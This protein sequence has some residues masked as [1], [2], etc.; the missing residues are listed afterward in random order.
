MI[1]AVIF[2]LDSCLSAADE[3]GRQLF[4]P[5][6]DAIVQ[7]SAGSH[8]ESVLQQAFHDM[9][10]IPYDVVAQKYAFTP[11]ML[12][13]GW[14]EMLQVEVRTP[15]FGYGDLG[16]LKTLPAML[17]LVTSGFRRL[18]ESKIRALGI[19]EL[20]TAVYVD[21]ID[22]PNHRGKEKLMADILQSRRLQPAEVLVVGDSPD[23]ELAVGSRL[24]IATVQTL[25]PGVP[26][27]PMATHHI[28]RLDELEP[29]LDAS[30]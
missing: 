15:M 28:R 6:F 18:Q 19:G 4:Q 21:A 9:W 14:K 26:Y 1:K 16:A 12:A 27:A 3:P 29:I 22:E 30:R 13:A 7:A 23:S 17:F 10:R 20:F 25:R 5:A 2:D 8:T 11:S 24:G